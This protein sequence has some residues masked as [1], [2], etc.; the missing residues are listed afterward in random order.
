M[1]CWK[2]FYE[3]IVDKYKYTSAEK[4]A[5]VPREKIVA[6]VCRRMI[7]RASA[8]VIVKVKFPLEVDSILVVVEEGFASVVV[9]GNI[10]SDAIFEMN[11]EIKM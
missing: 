6:V 5:L 8:R 3:G 4:E 9:Q 10:V 1:K 2:G 11:S 7:N